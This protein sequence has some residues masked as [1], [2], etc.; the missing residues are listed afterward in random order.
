M[1]WRSV[2][3]TLTLEGSLTLGVKQGVKIESV[4]VIALYAS[5]YLALVPYKHS[6]SA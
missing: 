4:L 6:D 2:A 3:L 1:R 5:W